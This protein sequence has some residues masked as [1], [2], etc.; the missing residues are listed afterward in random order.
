[1]YEVLIKLYYEMQYRKFTIEEISQMKDILNEYQ[2]R[3]IEVKLRRIKDVSTVGEKKS[4]R[5]QRKS[6]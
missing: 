4:D 3:T 5:G 1:M 6:L 2:N